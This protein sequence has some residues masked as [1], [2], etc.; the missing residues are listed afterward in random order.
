MLSVL[1]SQDCN[2]VLMLWFPEI[3]QEDPDLMG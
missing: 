3:P 2:E 1:L